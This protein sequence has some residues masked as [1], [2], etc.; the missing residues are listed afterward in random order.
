MSNNICSN[1]HLAVYL[2]TKVVLLGVPDTKGFYNICYIY[3][4]SQHQRISNMSPWLT[5]HVSDRC[6]NTGGFQIGTAFWLPWLTWGCIPLS[7]QDATLTYFVVSFCFPGLKA[8]DQIPIKDLWTSDVRSYL[9]ISPL[10]P[11]PIQDYGNSSININQSWKVRKLVQASQRLCLFELVTP[12]GIP[13]NMFAATR[14]FPWEGRVWSSLP[15]VTRI[16]GSLTC[17]NVDAC[18]CT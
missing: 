16:T 10:I 7:A 1:L 4:C 9:S 14:G 15:W 3:H 5:S 12:R 17:A 13:L 2:V 6:W 11:Y 18:R 8:S